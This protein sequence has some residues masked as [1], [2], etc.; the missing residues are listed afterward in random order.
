MFLNMLNA[1][2]TKLRT[3]KSFFWTTGLILVIA[4]GW[5]LINSLN[6]GEPVLGISPLQPN[7]LVAVL[8]L[9]GVPILMIQGAMVVTTEYRH[10][11]QSVTY[12]A[13]PNRWLVAVA[14]LVLY[15][16]IAALIMF[17][18]EV[19][20][21]VLADMTTNPAAAEAFHPF[22]EDSAQRLLWTAPLAAFGA[23]MFVQGLSLLLR[24]T[25]GTVAIALILY[26]GLE[27]VVRILPVVGDD[28]IHFMPFTAFTNWT[29]DMVEDSAP[30]DSVGMGGVVFF[31][32]AIILWG[33]GVLVLEKRDA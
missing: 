14:K 2:W 20:I 4:T 18:S 24:Q 22:S 21:F 8:L 6:A 19:Y 25:A 13:N 28:I 11:T 30:W 33:I 1:E 3:T 5:T 9:L 15:G 12:M 10:K 29:M 32:W 27:N 17:F 23:V 26:M 16:F 7:S 31:A